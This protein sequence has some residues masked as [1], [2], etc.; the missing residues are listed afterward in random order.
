MR[1]S[2]RRT[3]GMAF[4]LR[5]LFVLLI[6]S[7]LAG[8]VVGGLLRAG[9]AVSAAFDAPWAGRAVMDHA[10][11]MMCGFLGTVIGIER[12]VAVRSRFAFLAPAASGLAGVLILLGLEQHA[13]GIAVVSSLAFIAVNVVVWQRQRSA[14]TAVLLAGATA[15]L[16]G[17][18]LLA[19]AARPASVVP[20]WFCF[21]VF[22]IAAERLEMTRLTRRHRAATPALFAVLLA[23][24][25]GAAAFPLSP[26]WGGWIFGLALLGLASWLI[27]FDV[28]R[29][30]VMLR[31]LSRYM[32]V[33]L[34]LGYAW[35]AVAGVAWM[36]TA[37]GFH[38]RD[39]ALHALGLGF[40]FSMILGHA[41]V[42]VPAVARVK[43]SSGGRSM[44]CLSSCTRRS[45]CGSSGARPIPARGRWVRR[46]TPPQSCC[47]Q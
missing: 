13:A 32:A 4:A 2:S 20:W 17:N 6:V 23:M 35:L 44:R 21:L 37:A 47:S 45:R 26:V 9:V 40:I 27:A 42:I 7:S 3:S 16:V 5:S 14:H 15:W 25:A 39:M 46:A 34:L 29:R 12:A 24:L 43:R 11:L 18:L 36:A 10:F 30:T 33:C 19:L 22:T 8:G 31:G 38:G 1:T 41:P 28:A